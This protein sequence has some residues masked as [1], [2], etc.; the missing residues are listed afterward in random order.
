MLWSSVL[1]SRDEGILPEASGWDP[2][3][4]WP[5]PPERL[6]ADDL[7][8]AAFRSSLERLELDEPPEPS[9]LS[10]LG[11]C[12]KLMK[13]SVEW[14]FD[15]PNEN[16]LKNQPKT[17]DTSGIFIWSRPY[18]EIKTYWDCRNLWSEMKYVH[19]YCMIDKCW[20]VP[21]LSYLEAL[22]TP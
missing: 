2:R 9:P 5:W 8:A 4:P 13:L 3:P 21:Y 22:L 10:P 12:K 14:S 11:T 7:A 20:K 18:Y 1:L 17:L 6:P 16:I 15:F 19:K